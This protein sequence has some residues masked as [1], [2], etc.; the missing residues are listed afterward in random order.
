MGNSNY[1]GMPEPIKE[2]LETKG[3]KSDKKAEMKGVKLST[4]KE[5]SKDYKLAAAWLEKLDGGD[6]LQ[7]L[8]TIETITYDL[9]RLNIFL[10]VT[11]VL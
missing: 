5:G 3:K 7:K 8:A 1:S 11:F 4:L 2:T 10:S 9:S 6:G